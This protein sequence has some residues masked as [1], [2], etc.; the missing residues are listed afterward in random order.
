MLELDQGDMLSDSELKDFLELDQLDTS[1]K[2]TKLKDFL[3]L[4]QLD[5]LSESEL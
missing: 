2:Y 4:D 3:E 5:M 1:I